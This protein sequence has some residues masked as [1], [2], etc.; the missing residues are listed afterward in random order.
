MLSGMAQIVVRRM[1]ME[2]DRCIVH[3]VSNDLFFFWKN[4]TVLDCS[5]SV[6][7]QAVQAATDE[8]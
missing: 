7:K 3:A 1:E 8:T 4:V 5:S 2:N 6:R